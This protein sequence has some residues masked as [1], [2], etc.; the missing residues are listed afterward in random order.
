MPLS[1]YQKKEKGCNQEVPD[2]PIPDM[3]DGLGRGACV[4]LKP[5]QTQ[6]SFNS[7]VPRYQIDFLGCNVAESLVCRNAECR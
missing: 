2:P 3:I 6:A 7:S 5:R 4:T 1:L